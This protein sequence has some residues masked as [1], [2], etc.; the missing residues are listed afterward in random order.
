M[1]IEKDVFDI[2]DRIKEIDSDYYIE[3]NFKTNKFE[4][5]GKGGAKLLVFPFESLDE[6]AILHARRTRVERIEKIIAEIDKN[7]ADLE[8]KARKN[9]KE[10]IWEMGDGRW[11][12]KG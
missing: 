3:F 4:L 11:E 5:F 8:A 9:A 12:T 10:K 2:A 1:K 7:N 6:R